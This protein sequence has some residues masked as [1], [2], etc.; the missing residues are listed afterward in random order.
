LR[1]KTKRLELIAANANLIRAEISDRERFARL[2]EARVPRAREQEPDHQETMENMA[3]A[4][5]KGPEQVGWWCWYLVLHNRVTGHRVLIGDGGFKGPPDDDG[6]VEIGYSLL[7]PY[8]NRGYTT[9][10]V[11]AL[12]SWAFQHPQVTRV[13]AEAQ[14][15]NI[16]SIRVLQKAGFNEAGPGSQRSHVRFEMARQDFR[17]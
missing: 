9:E 1:V 3:Q 17:S 8:R 6:V 10:A 16:A 4:L 15:G 14:L 12:V 5:E 13:I 11:K 2:L 7:Q